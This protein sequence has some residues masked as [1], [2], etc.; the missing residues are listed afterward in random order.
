MIEWMTRGNKG[1]SQLAP[2]AT[3]W[4]LVVLRFAN[5]LR[6]FV[7]FDVLG[8]LCVPLRLCGAPG[9]CQVVIRWCLISDLCQ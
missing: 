3:V 8:E 1:R 5:L 2:A 6:V 7:L 4:H 9:L